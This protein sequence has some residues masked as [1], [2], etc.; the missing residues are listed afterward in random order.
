MWRCRQA[1]MEAG[2][3]GS[4]AAAHRVMGVSVSEGGGRAVAN[5]V[6]SVKVKLKLSRTV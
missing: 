3:C 1:K 4:R 5:R 6:I 2:E